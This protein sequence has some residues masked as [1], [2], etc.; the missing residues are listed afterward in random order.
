VP[1]EDD[2]PVA[3]VPAPP[4]RNSRSVSRCTGDESMRSTATWP[5]R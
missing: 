3:A 4:A 1:G 5:G 2:Q